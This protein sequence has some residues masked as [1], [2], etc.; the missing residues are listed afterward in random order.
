[1]TIAMTLQRYLADRK[2][3]YD[4]V[5]HP[6]TMSATRTAQAS[7]ISGDCLAKAVVVKDAEGFRLAVLPASYHIEME[8]LSDLL[9]QDAGLASEEEASGL[10]ADCETGAFPALGPAYGLDMI[11]DDSLQ[12][13]PEV[14]L[15]GGDH[16][17]LV[18]LDAKQFRA[19]TKDSPHGRF[20]LRG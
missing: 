16:A 13:Q 7:H 5:T 17:S 18:H 10:F 11:V 9:T 14:Y 6:R 2:V 15:E 12:E 19:L 1:M 20:S 3:K 4:V 8:L